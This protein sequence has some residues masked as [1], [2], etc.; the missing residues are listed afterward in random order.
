MFFEFLLDQGLVDKLA[1][2]YPSPRKRHQVPPWMYASSQV[3]LRL[4]GFTSFHSYPL[5]VRAGGLIDASGPEVARRQ[6][7]PDTG[8]MPLWCARFNDRN[9]GPR[10]TPCDQDYLHKHCDRPGERFV[11]A[12]PQVLRANQAETPALWELVDRFVESVGRD[13]VKVLI[14]DRG[15]RTRCSSGR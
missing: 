12:G 4:H 11:V 6:V 14:L 15:I 1:R 9:L 3:S 13:V 8:H 5:I 2:H 7:D 10:S